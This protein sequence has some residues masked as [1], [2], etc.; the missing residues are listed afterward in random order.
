MKNIK[1]LALAL[2]CALLIASCS[3]KNS[4]ELLPGINQGQCDT[5][6]YSVGVSLA[7]MIKQSGIECINYDM[8][9]KG[10]K[11]FFALDPA[12]STSKLKLDDEV[13]GQA[14]QNYMMESQKAKEQLEENK[15]KEFFAKLKKE[16][17]DVQETESG[18]CYQI[19]EAGNAEM[20]PAD[21]DTVNVLYTG[22]RPDGTVF[23]STEKNN[24][25]EAV[26]FTLQRVIPGW[27][28]GMELIGEGGKIKLWVPF[29]LGY[30]PRAMSAE[31]PAYSTLI[32]DVELVKV[33]KVAATEEAVELK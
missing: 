11:D 29:R 14:I 22:T 31:L 21:A 20:I 26:E 32:F 5:A 15:E 25:G 8:M 27:R 24:N 30:G 2:G 17:P 23:D 1:V 18:L 16:N 10:M 28:E 12:D 19:L 13:I 7:S 6:S 3:S 4:C 9:L 33:K